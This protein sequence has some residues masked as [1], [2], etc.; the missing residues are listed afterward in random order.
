MRSLGVAGELEHL[1]GGEL[2]DLLDTVADVDE[3]LL[4]L[5]RGAAL[6]TGDIAIAAAG[7]ALANGAGP[8]ADTVEGLADVDDD[9]HDLTILLL[10][11]GV[12]D[13]SQHDVQPQLVNVDAALVLEL[14]GPLAAMLILGVLPLGSHAGLEEVVVGLEGEVGDRCDVVL[15]RVSCFEQQKAGEGGMVDIRRYPRIPRPS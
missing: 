4:A 5:L 1:V 10:L 14:V 8:D 13:G 3:D 2:Q 9:A 11:H 6:A 12:S 7:D 15:E